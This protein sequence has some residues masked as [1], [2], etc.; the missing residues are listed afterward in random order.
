MK[1]SN[2]NEFVEINDNR[3]ILFNTFTKKFF[4]MDNEKKSTIESLMGNM[5]KQQYEINEA[6]LFKKLARAGMVIGDE[7]NELD[8]IAELE[9]KVK[10]NDDFYIVVIKPTFDCNFRCVY[11]GQD[12]KKDILDDANA[13]KILKFID[14]I[15]KEVKYVNITWYGGEP[16]MEIQRIEQITKATKD[17]CKAND[18]KFDA[19]IVTNGYLLNDELIEKVEELSFSNVQ[20]TLDG[21]EKYHDAARPHENGRGSYKTI[22]ENVLKL[23]K[24]DIRLIL[25][26]NINED[27]HDG[28]VEL[29]DIIPENKRSKVRVDL[30]NWF[31]NKERLNFY[32]IYMKSIEKGYRYQNTSNSYV[33]CEGSYKNIASF[34]P[35]G[36]IGFCSQEMSTANCYGKLDDFG[37]VEIENKQLY[38]NFH[39]ILTL[40]SNVCRSCKQLPMCMG[41]CK[42]ARYADNE[43]CLG[44]GPSG[45]RLED[46]IRLYYHDAEKYTNIEDYDI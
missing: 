5:N 31:Q 8:R 26:V 33:V 29:L 18:C 21:T 41:G 37:V 16:L 23:I 32:E 6:N 13:D 39:D 17:I 38:C 22:V 42:K 4:V 40:E 43:V 7:Y 36:E 1:A 20:I 12:H 14:K 2:Y 15:S 45:L 30:V 24:K 35:N 19:N 27:N 25:R 46:K 11:C 9:K 44:D 3:H 34:L 28:I 10:A